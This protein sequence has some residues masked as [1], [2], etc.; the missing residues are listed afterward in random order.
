MSLTVEALAQEIERTGITGA[1]SFIAAA[2]FPFI[3]R[4]IAAGQQGDDIEQIAAECGAV[5]GYTGPGGELAEAAFSR[6][7]LYEFAR[8]LAT[9]KPAG[10]VPLPQPVATLLRDGRWEVRFPVGSAGFVGTPE[11]FTKQQLTAYGDAREATAVAEL[12]QTLAQIERENIEGWKQATHWREKC[13][14]AGRADAVPNL[15]GWRVVPF[16]GSFKRGD[17]CWEVCAPNGSGGVIDKKEV[18]W[19]LAGLLDML[20]ASPL[21]QQPAAEDERRQP[22]CCGG[23]GV[24][25]NG[26][27]GITDCP[28]CTSEPIADGREAVAWIDKGGGIAAVGTHADA[29]RA[30]PDGVHDLYT[31]PVADAEAARPMDTAPRDGTLVRLLV[32]FSEHDV[33]DSEGPHWTIGA[34]PGE[35]DE[36]SDWQFAGWCWSHDHFTEG[37][38]TPI[39][40]LPFAV[41]AARK[42]TG[43][44]HA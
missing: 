26:L 35:G 28:V 10:A 43:A 16:T 31:H 33:E 17:E 37:K 25:M 32:E 12:R 40:W 44:D 30:L 13:E 11:V 34:W 27:D 36:N 18:P 7:G 21:P 4:H 6:K 9:P 42:A 19:P 29:W 3:E 8:R 5:I 20:A 39:G 1:P 23:T 15:Q 14:A 24:V 22:R 38:G 2:I 41:D